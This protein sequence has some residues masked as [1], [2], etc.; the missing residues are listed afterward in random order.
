LFLKKVTKFRESSVVPKEWAL[1]LGKKV[2]E[3]FSHNAVS[4]VYDLEIGGYFR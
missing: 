4:K 2:R 3:R 1:D